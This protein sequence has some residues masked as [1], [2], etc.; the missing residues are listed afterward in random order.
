MRVEE[1]SNERKGYEADETE[2]ERERSFNK[3]GEEQSFNKREILKVSQ[4]ARNGGARPTE[5]GLKEFVAFTFRQC[6]LGV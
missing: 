5:E 3:E 1:Y 4:R 6:P 2:L